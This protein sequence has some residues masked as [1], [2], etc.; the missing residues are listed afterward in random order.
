MTPAMAETAVTSAMR[1]ARPAV[2]EPMDLAVIEAMHVADMMEPAI[3]PP[4]VAAPAPISVAIIGI[5]FRAGPIRAVIA[6]GHRHIAIGRRGA[7]CQTEC[8][9]AEQRQAGQ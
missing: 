4:M 2:A 5:R 7:P 3:A 8:R 1:E 6:S 9:A